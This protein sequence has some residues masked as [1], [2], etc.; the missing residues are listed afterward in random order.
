MVDKLFIDGE[1]FRLE[2][3]ESDDDDDMDIYPVTNPEPDEAVAATIASQLSASAPTFYPG[4]RGRG[5]GRGGHRGRGRNLR[6]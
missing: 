6:K 2:E 5:R 3:S 1:L 4:N